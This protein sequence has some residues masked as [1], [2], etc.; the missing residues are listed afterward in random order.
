MLKWLRLC[1][2]FLMFV[3]VLPQPVLAQTLPRKILALY[4]PAEHPDFFYSNLHQ[5]AEFPLNHLGMMLEYHSINEPIPHPNSKTDFHAILSWFRHPQAIKN[6]E[7]Y[8]KSLLQWMDAG[9]KLVILEHPGFLSHQL[10]TVCQQ[11]FVKLGVRYEAEQSDNPYFI[12]YVQKQSDMIEFERKLTNLDSLGFAI[13]APL[14]QNK[15]KIYLLAKRKDMP[16]R[17]SALVFA[18]SH[19]A[20]VYP[21]YA[22]ILSYDRRIAQWRINPFKFFNEVLQLQTWPRPDVTTLYGRRIFFT[23]VDGDGIFNISRQDQ[24]NYSGEIILNEVVQKYPLLPITLSYITYYFEDKKYLND[25]EKKLYY[26]LSTPPHVEIASHT[27]AHPLRWDL[28]T[29]SFHPKNYQMNPQREIVGAVQEI[30]KLFTA[31]AIPKPIQILQW[32]GDCKPTEPQLALAEQSGLFNINGGDSRFDSEYSSYSHVAPIGMQR[33]KYLQIY[34][35]A[36][37]ENIY[38]N[39]WQGPFY[40]FREVLHTFQNT[41]TPLRVKPINIY[42]HF[43]VAEYFESLQVLKNIF[44]KVLS[45]KIFALFTSDYIRLA[46]DFYQ[47]KMEAIGKGFTMQHAGLLRTLRIDQTN[48]FVDMQAST[49]ILG[50]KHEQGNLYVHLAAGTKAKLFL[51]ETPPKQ[52]YLQEASFWPS[53]FHITPNLGRF[54][55]QGYWQSEIVLAN[56]LPLKSYEV[57]EANETYLVQSDAQGQLKIYFHRVEIDKIPTQVEI[58]VK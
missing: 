4:D 55:K 38:T 53:D 29:L 24:K 3:G 26:D 9:K 16:S 31:L 10:P 56:M 6:P 37:N 11:V 7:T 42:Y 51:S 48:Q 33:G 58:R 43:Y 19:G 5:Y 40:G 2:L 35:G 13:F 36:P 1:V 22:N 30:N 45:Q 50:F 8:C 18:N 28:G 52:P 17:P 15:L 27:Y 41:E 44:E 54:K 32:S 47:I 12:D 57:S 14:D 25:R 20:F 23:H 39:L 49:G 46:Q 21:G 34:S